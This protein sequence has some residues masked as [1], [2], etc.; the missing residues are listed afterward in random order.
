MGGQCRGGGGRRTQTPFPFQTRGKRLPH[1]FSLRHKMNTDQASQPNSRHT[2][3]PYQCFDTARCPNPPHSLMPSPV[4]DGVSAP[5]RL[6]FTLYQRHTRTLIPGDRRD[7]NRN[8]STEYRV[9]QTHRY[10]ITL[11]VVGSHAE[12]QGCGTVSLGSVA[13]DSLPFRRKPVL[14]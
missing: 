11:S 13:T 8:S 9:G 5:P 4:F 12:A 10:Q 14:Q 1:R 2:C 7:E 6:K 3:Q